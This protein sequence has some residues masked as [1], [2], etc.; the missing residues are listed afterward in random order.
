MPII[1]P[2]SHPG[3]EAAAAGLR[4]RGVRLRRQ[5]DAFFIRP[6]G[7]DRHPELANDYFGNYERL[8]Y[9]AQTDDPELEKVAIRAAEML[10]LRYE[11]RLTGYGD[12]TKALAK[13]ADLD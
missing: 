12:L 2:E 7:L 13:A 4:D 10:G 9:L 11:R 5:F 6:L 8:I 1:V 3:A